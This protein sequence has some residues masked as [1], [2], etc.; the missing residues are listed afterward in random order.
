MLAN[1]EFKDNYV[2]GKGTVGTAKKEI[3][4]YVFSLYSKMPSVR[5]EYLAR[6]RI[7]VHSRLN[8]ELSGAY[9]VGSLSYEQIVDEVN[10]KEAKLDTYLETIKV[11]LRCGYC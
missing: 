7:S 3:S 5:P 9:F 1:I 11:S 8:F 6:V 10:A 4:D 2:W